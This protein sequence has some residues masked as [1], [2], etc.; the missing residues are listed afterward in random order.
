MSADGE[1]HGVSHG[2]VCYLQIPAREV[3]ASSAFYA[4]VFGWQVEAGH[5]GFETPGLIGQWVQD[6]AP[7]AGDGIL[8]WGASGGLG[9]APARAGR[10]G[11]VGVDEGLPPAHGPTAAGRASSGG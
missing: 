8:A 2:Q 6:R 11:G 5:D 10:A 9:A 4:R 3:S 7:V 1:S